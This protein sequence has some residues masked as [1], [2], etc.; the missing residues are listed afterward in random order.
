MSAAHEPQIEELAAL[1][2]A[3]GRAELLPRY[4][5]VAA[6]RKDDGSLLTEADLAV[7]QRLQAELAARWPQYGFLGEE[8]TR[9]EQEQLLARPD[10]GFW[11]LDPLD[12]TTNFAA[13]IPLFSISLALLIQG[14]PVLGVVYDPSRDECFAAARGA[15]A[16]LNGAPLGVRR[17]S[18]PLAGGIGLI[19]FKRLP[20]PLAA[21]LAQQPPV[22]SVRSVGSVA[23]EWCWLAAG[24]AHV[25]LHGRQMLWD[26]AAGNVVLTEAGGQ[27]VTMDGEPAFRASLTPR[28]VVAA[29]EPALLDEF[30]AWIAGT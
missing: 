7:Q 26:N 28:S 14:E 18:G 1:V 4:E 25:Y 27:A 13:G 9:T 20:A 23:L 12:G 6:M 29:L 17:P 24:R 3:V 10:H 2:R 8:M 15:G 21:R 22:R 30:R 5:R 11:C 16:W 19:D